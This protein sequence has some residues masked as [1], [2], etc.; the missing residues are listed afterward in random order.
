[1]FISFY[2]KLGTE[3]RMIDYY[4]SND[5]P[6]K[7]YVEVLQQKTYKYGRPFGPHHIAVRERSTGKSRLE[8]ARALGINF[9][10]TPSLPIDDGINAGRMMFDR[11]WIDETNCAFFL[12]AIAQYRR[13]WD[14]KKGM[15]KEKPLH[16]WTSHAADVHRYAALV[17]TQM[18][19]Q[20]FTPHRRPA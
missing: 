7:H 5:K 3:L 16:D 9:E 4:E 17:E 8:A 20:T 11:L 15:F 14:D 13:E 2:Q 19:N 6:L 12:D 10:I 18:K 1:M